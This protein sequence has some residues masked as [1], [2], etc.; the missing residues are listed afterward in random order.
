[1]KTDDELE[2]FTKE[3]AKAWRDVPD[4][5][6]WVEWIR[7]NID[8]EEFLR[9]C[10]VAQWR[11]IDALEAKVAWESDLAESRMREIVRLREELAAVRGGG[12]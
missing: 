4:A 3:G 5:S 12:E 2:A 1:M 10:V 7:G 9:S 8:D 6:A 11:M